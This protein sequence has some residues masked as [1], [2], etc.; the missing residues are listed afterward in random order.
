MRT[1]FQLIEQST[2]AILV[3]SLELADR[4]WS[5]L[6]GLQ[7]RSSLPAG[8]GLL[9]VPCSSLHTFF[10][11]FAIDL[12][13]LDRRGEVVAVRKQVRPW[14]VVLPIRH[15]HAILEMPS[16]AAHVQP[17]QRLRLAPTANAAQLRKSLKFLA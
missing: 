11:R 9:L 12:V 3:E 1:E 5:R 17:G 7:F 15:A 4:F 10:V 13:I 6:V 2:G 14:R 16:G 8:H